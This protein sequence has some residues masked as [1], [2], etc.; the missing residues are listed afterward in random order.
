MIAF[1][2]PEPPE[3]RLRVWLQAEYEKAQV[4]ARRARGGRS[5]S[6][7]QHKHCSAVSRMCALGETM[8]QLGRIVG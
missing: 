5:G 7:D 3:A 2:R 4:A 8:Q 1:V 6:L